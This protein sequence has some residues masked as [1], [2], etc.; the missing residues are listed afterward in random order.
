MRY[1]TYISDA[2]V[3]MLLTQVPKG[4]KQKIAAEVG[5]NLGVVS[6]KIAVEAQTL[7]TRVARLKV[8]EAYVRETEEVGSP[9]VPKTWI[10]G[11][12]AAVGVDLGEGALLY[13]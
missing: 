6:G 4:L 9:S 8:V 10:E 11:R 7:D 12:T 1:Y 3:D 13:I 2:K 5:F